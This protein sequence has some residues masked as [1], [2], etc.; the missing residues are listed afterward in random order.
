MSGLPKKAMSTNSERVLGRGAAT[1]QC[2]ALFDAE[3]IRLLEIEHLI[4][5]DSAPPMTRAGIAVA[6]LVLALAP[7]A[8]L[9]CIPCG[10]GNN[11]GD[12]FEAAIV[13]T[14][15]GNPSSLLN[16]QASTL[17]L[18]MEPWRANARL[19]QGSTFK[20]LLRKS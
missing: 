19:A 2:P 13:Y 15:R 1:I 8:R 17:E 11:G 10:P 12:G 5:P 7:H 6:K 18:G 9:I 16:C 3:A 14:D 20:A 4:A